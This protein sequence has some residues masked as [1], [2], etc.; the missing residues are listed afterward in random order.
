MSARH[1]TSSAAC[2]AALVGSD[3]A[4]DPTPELTGKPNAVRNPQVV[5]R[6]VR[7]STMLRNGADDFPGTVRRYELNPAVRR[8]GG[9]DAITVSK[10]ENH[11]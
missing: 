7:L 4:M 11:Q 10:L 9:G 3:S 6:F 2:M 1:A 8:V 5:K